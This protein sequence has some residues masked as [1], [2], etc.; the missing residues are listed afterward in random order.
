[1]HRNSTLPV[2][3]AELYYESEGSGPAVVLVHGFGLD[4]RMWDDQVA[5]LRDIATVVRYDVRG[6]GRSSGPA[7]D[8][9][10]SHSGDLLA[11]LEHLGITGALLVG[12]SMGGLIALHTALVA[13][14]RVRGLVL[15]DSLLDGIGWDDDSE[16]AMSAVQRAAASDVEAG[17]ELWLAH[18]LFAAARRNP[19]VATR[20]RAMVSAYSGVHWTQHDPHRPWSPQPI[21]ALE[22]IAV[23]TTVVVGELDVPCFRTMASVLADRIPGAQLLTVPGSGHMVN[24]EAPSAVNAVLRPAVDEH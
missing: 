19:A 5:A 20:L 16:R 1:M 11:L 18:P 22:R 13:P 8:L 21:E 2:P 3:G 6:F 15:L 23:P 9:A 14:E 7:P 10:Y 24:M 17:R 4:A 12:L